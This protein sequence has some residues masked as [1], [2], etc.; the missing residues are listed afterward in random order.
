MAVI[1]ILA[2]ML[3]NALSQVIVKVVCVRAKSARH[4]PVQTRSKTA[5]KQTLIAAVIVVHALMLLNA[6]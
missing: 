6:F 3:L 2:L 5:M 4:Q 1:V